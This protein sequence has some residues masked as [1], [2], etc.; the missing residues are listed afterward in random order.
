MSDEAGAA[1]QPD[2]SGGQAQ[3]AQVSASTEVRNP[4]P[5]GNVKPRPESPLTYDETTGRWVAKTKVDGTERVVPWEDLHRDAQ[6]AKSAQERFEEAKAIKRQATELAAHHRAL[7]E[8]FIDPRR[9]LE[10]WAAQGLDPTQMLAHMQRELEAERNLTPEQRELR[11]YRAEAA[12]REAAE[13]KQQAEAQRAQEEAAQVAADQKYEKA[14]IRHMDALN[15]PQSPTLRSHMAQILWATHDHCTEK[16]I[17]MS[18]REA[19]QQAQQTM[20]EMARDV[21]A[22]MTPEERA[23]LLGAD[24]VTGIAASSVARAAPIPRTVVG[25]H[26]PRERDGRFSRFTPFSGTAHFSRLADEAEN[27]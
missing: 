13:R 7:Q 19:A 20:R 27:R 18:V 14:F 6:L 11:K 3:D 5:D 10:T 25:N 2:T 24:I 16:G 22:A 17:Q 15:V 4:A 21:I 12:Q 26:Q 8:A 23:Q 9:A 1:T